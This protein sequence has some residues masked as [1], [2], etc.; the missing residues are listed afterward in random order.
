[1]STFTEKSTSMESNDIKAYTTS[2]IGIWTLFTPNDVDSSFPAAKQKWNAILSAYP[3]VLRFFRD[4]YGLQPY[5][6]VLFI[7]LKLW[8]GMK[9]LVELYVYGRLLRIIEVGLTKGQPDATAIMQALVAHMISVTVSAIAQWTQQYIS[10]VLENSVEQYFEEYLLRAKLRL[11][12]STIDAG[13]MRS[14][15]S[16]YYAWRSFSGLCDAFA[17]LFGLLIQLAFIAQ[18]PAGG[19]LFTL[20]AIV[21]PMVA[22]TGRRTLS[23][24][25]FGAYSGNA[26]YLRMRSL[27]S[28]SA[29][30]FRE[31]VISGDLVGWIT[32]GTTPHLGPGRCRFYITESQKALHTEYQRARSSLGSVLSQDVQSLYGIQESPAHGIALEWAG[33][34]PTLYW[35][36]SAMLWP[37]KFSMTS[38]VIL[39]SYSAS[40]SSSLSQL[41]YHSSSVGTHFWNVKILYESGEIQNPIVDGDVTYPRPTA[42][43]PKGAEIELK[44]VSFA[45]PGDKS[46]EAALKDISF[47]IP[48]GSLVVIVGANGSGKSTIIKLLTRLYD[49]DAGVVLVDGLPIQSYCMADL[50]RTQATLTQDHKL[51]P[52]TLAQNIGLGDTKHIE[53]TDMIKEAAREGGAAAVLDKLKEGVQTTLAPIRTAFKCSMD[54]DNLTHK[55]LKNIINKLECNTEVSGGEKQRLVASRTFMRLRT[56]HIK[57]LNIDEPSSALDPRGEFELFERLRQVGEGKTTI[58][59]THRFGHLTKHADIII[60]MKEG[61]VS[62]LGTHKDLMASEGEYAS[63]YN[64]QAQAFAEFGA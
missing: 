59:V 2:K 13:G 47:R 51:Y 20:S 57:L 1:M 27:R 22:M 48:A 50:R 10:P 41:F 62:E 38:I 16:S 21:R 15:A 9:S 53:N 44:N 36:L 52:L 45:Y 58:F 30:N 63:L 40:L 54:D 25:S 14:Q 46:K 32:A 43:T 60:C 6:V 23:L 37:S 42:D 5:F 61:K 33:Q 35:A 29:R 49:V 28:M 18:Q 3:L 17:S 31:D 26:P 4:I 55:A 12:I 64:I 34:L 7:A 39:Q 19:S 8:E 56:G 11:D 24:K